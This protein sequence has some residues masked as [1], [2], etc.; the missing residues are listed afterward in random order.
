MESVTLR[1]P[2]DITLGLNDSFIIKRVFLSFFQAFFAQH[3]KYTWTP[4]NATKILVLDKYSMDTAPLESKPAIIIS[5]GYMRFMGSSIG[6]K[7]RQSLY[8]DNVTYTDIL[9]GSVTLNCLAKNGLV[10]E[11]LAFTVRNAIIGFKKQLMQNGIHTINSVVVGEESSV[12]AD[13]DIVLQVVP[14]Q[15][16]FTKQTF[17]QGIE[18]FYATSATLT[19]SGTNYGN[20][21]GLYYNT[22]SPYQ[23]FEN[24]EYTVFESGII[25]VSGFAPPLG[26]AINLRYIDA[27]T[28]TEQSETPSGTIN[29]T[30]RTFYTSQEIYGYSPL[31]GAITLS[32]ITIIAE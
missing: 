26:S 20:Y 19:F 12:K 31:L 24:N 14:V 5:R 7:L 29:G 22:S 3:S 9:V 18:D 1:E 30:N 10:C 21:S 32:G 6:Q 17:I 25:F 23:A 15:V 4:T 13:S 2:S 16:E 8:S 28:L 11:E 27:I